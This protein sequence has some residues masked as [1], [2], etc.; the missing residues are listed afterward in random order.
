MRPLLSEMPLGPVLLQLGLTLAPE[1]RPRSG[2]EDQRLAD[3]LSSLV[4]L[5][6]LS[7]RSP[8]S[9]ERCSLLYRCLA[10]GCLSS[11]LVLAELGALPPLNPEDASA[12]LCLV[13]SAPHYWHE[14]AAFPL[15]SRLVA[16][17]GLDLN[18]LQ[19]SGP[20]QGQGYLHVLFK[21]GVVMRY[22][23]TSPL[24]AHP[25]A[26]SQLSFD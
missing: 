25:L 17:G 8:V 9:A 4:R 26:L 14:S 16:E 19:P 18:R 6:G 12:S 23:S 2:P 21:K 5:G 7:P 13:L 3:A 15:I 11:A 1:P 24:P 22:L 10:E 20:H